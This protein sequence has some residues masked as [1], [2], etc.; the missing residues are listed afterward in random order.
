MSPSKYLISTLLVG[1]VLVFSDLGA[2]WGSQGT[3]SF[4]DITLQAGTGGPTGA[5]KTGGHGAMF[6]DVNEDGFPD[7]YITMNF[8]DPMADLFFRNIGGSTLFSNEGSIR[9]IDDFDGGSHGATFADLDNDG[10]FDLFNGTTTPLLGFPA[11]NNIFENFGTGFFAEVTAT[12]GIPLDREWPTRSVIA[13]D[14]D[15]DGDLDLFGVTNHRGSNDPPDERNEVYLNIGNLQ[16][17]SINSG[18]LFT[19]PCGQGATDTDYDG[20]GDIDVFCGNATGDVNILQNDGTG[21]FILIPP[22]SI[23][24]Q[25]RSRDGITTADVDNDGDLDLLLASSNEGHLY[26]NQ[27]SGT[28]SF[29]QSFLNT[30]GY[31]GA[32]ADLDNDG[33]LDLVFAGDDQVYLNDGSG[34]FS[35]GPAVPVSG[36]NDPRAIAFADIDN[37]GDLDFAIGAKRS[38]NWLVQ[39]DYNGGNW[40]KISLVSP[41]GQAGAF[42]TKVRVYPQGNA[43]GILLGMREAR[44]NAGYMGQDDP[45]IH[46]GLGS[47]T[48]VDIVVTFLDGSE[49][50]LFGVTSGTS[51]TINGCTDNDGDGYSTCNGDCNDADSNINP[52]SAE[53]CNGEDDNCD[54]QV[55][56]GV[57]TTY[58]PDNDI[59]G[60]GDI[61]SPIQACTIPP[62]YVTDSTDCDDTDATVNPAGTEVCTDGKDNDCD[63]SQDCVDSECITDIACVECT[64]IDGDSYSLE[65]GL[66]GPPD[67]DDANSSI[68]PGAT[69]TCN[70]IDDNCNFSVDEEVTITFYMDFDSDGFGDIGSPTQAC[71]APIGYVENNS[72][73]ND[74][75]A[76]ISPNANEVCSDQIDNNCDGQSD[77]NDDNCSGDPVCSTS[78]GGGGGGCSIVSNK[79]GKLAVFGEY[80]LLFIAALLFA[81]RNKRG[82]TKDLKFEN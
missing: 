65:G 18:A 19:A 47:H 68:N 57:T 10:D 50:S 53:I 64:D 14:M 81:L 33:D 58:Y 32:F 45:T 28:F 35:M 69:E 42:G 67:C 7:L 27:G 70:E 73:C 6:A 30:I 15:R 71:T 25:H 59:D 75:D 20:D 43:G 22:A 11:Y 44:S 2:S 5:G 9:G 56:E 76:L 38:R 3:L 8:D 24:I 16:F 40:L 49:I 78:D 31:M 17:A 66:C 21:N 62:G 82:R 63:G 48:S 26:L 52:G 51:L 46:F 1:L 61:K 74:N 37:D 12:S 55:D 60:Y 79:Q 29:H 4:T 77:C 80:G 23:G 39:N 36:I 72:D 54:Q 13:F 34:N 41:Q